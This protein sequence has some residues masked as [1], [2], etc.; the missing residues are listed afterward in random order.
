MS[1]GA[2]GRGCAGPWGGD[3]LGWGTVPC[4]ALLPPP[5]LQHSLLGLFRPPAHGSGHGS[6][7]CPCHRPDGALGA[8]P[9]HAGG[10]WR[11]H[12][13]P[14]GVCCRWGVE[15]PLP[16]PKALGEEQSPVG[17]TPLN[18]CRCQLQLWPLNA[19]PRGTDSPAEAHR[20]GDGPGDGDGGTDGSRRA[21]PHPCVLS[22]PHLSRREA[23]R[24]LE[25]GAPSV[26]LESFLR[27]P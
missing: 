7:G 27:T 23:R 1:A 9:G 18:G 3:S 25:P 26:S 24:G 19:V 13:V 4:L 6:V 10:S 15:T 14:P 17:F 5:A 2:R 16:H 20:G 22:A 21:G 8:S 11:S 12:C